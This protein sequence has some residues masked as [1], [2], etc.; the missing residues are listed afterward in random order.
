[1]TF[2]ALARGCLALIA[3]ALLA[4]VMSAPASAANTRVSITDFKW[5]KEPTVDL[6][7]SV[8][9]DWLGPDLQ[10]SVTGQEPNATQW[11]SHPGI[12]SPRQ[13]LGGTFT[14]TFDQPGEY[15][16][17][18]KLHP[19][20]VR[21]VVTVTDQPGDPL[22]DPGPQP[23]L[24]FD[25]EPPQVE[26]LRIAH[27]VLGPRGKGTGMYLEVSEKSTASID[28]YRIVRKSQGKKK[29]R[30]VRRFAG[31][32]ERNLHIGI[33][34]VRFANRSATFRAKPGRYVARVRV[35]DQNTNAS[36]TFKLRFEIKG[37]KKRKRR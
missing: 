28:Y 23:P 37:K 27:Y 2:G 21:G 12:P 32:H 4:G 29:F 17:V 6:G 25:L 24:N 7:E 5:S 20:A 18:C 36:P 26:G 34:T 10:H 16:F 14:V 13:N 11:D 8:T 33:N 3:A 19:Q 22:S 1:M 31:Y 9:W 35:D 15:L 30:N